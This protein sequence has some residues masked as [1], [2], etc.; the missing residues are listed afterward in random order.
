LPA[1][2]SQDLLKL[3]H[4]REGVVNL[5]VELVAEYQISKCEDSVGVVPIRS[6]GTLVA[7]TLDD[8]SD[9]FSFVIFLLA[10]ESDSE[11]DLSREGAKVVLAQGSFSDRQRFTVHLLC[12]N[13]IAKSALRSGKVADGEQCIQLFLPVSLDA[14]VAYFDYE[15]VCV[16]QELLS[17]VQI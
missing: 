16:V 12:F 13:V 1:D 4:S 11:V 8:F 3:G 2:R 15:V 5:A 7:M 6:R 14:L 9:L 17:T 10:N